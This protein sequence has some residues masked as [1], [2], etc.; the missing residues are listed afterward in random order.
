MLEEPVTM[1]DVT[2][3]TDDFQVKLIFMYIS[4]FIPRKLLNGSVFLN[5]E[6]IFFIV[7]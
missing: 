6:D 7:S 4:I 3:T 1:Y 2:G 5:I